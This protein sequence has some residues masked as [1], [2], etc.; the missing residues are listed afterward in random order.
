MWAHSGEHPAPK[1]AK[2]DHAVRIPG[3]RQVAVQPR[4]AEDPQ[5]MTLTETSSFGVESFEE[6]HETSKITSNGD[7]ENEPPGRN[8][9][10]SLLEQRR[11]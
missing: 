6:C 2:G 4:M 9:H 8:Q 1:V 11:L 5:G 7:P 3:Y 10:R